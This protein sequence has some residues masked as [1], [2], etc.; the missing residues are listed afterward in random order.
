MGI[1]ERGRVCTPGSGTC[2]R[3]RKRR[4]GAAA[5]GC[6]RARAAPPGADAVQKHRGP[7]SE[8]PHTAPTRPSQCLQQLLAHRD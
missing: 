4:E 7:Y 1:T 5:P 2:R 8:S 6:W 3:V